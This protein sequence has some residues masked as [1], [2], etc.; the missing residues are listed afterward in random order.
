MAKYTM[1]LRDIVESQNV[2]LFDFDYEYYADNYALQ[3]RFE[4]M[5][6]QHYYFHEIG[7]ETVERFK[8]NL[9]AKL[10]LNAPLYR[11]YWDSYLKSKNIDFTVN[12]EYLETVTR[13][14]T[15]ENESSSN[16][17]NSTISRNEGENSYNGTTKTSSLADGVS[18][19]R[20][21][22]DYVTGITHD[23]NKTKTEDV[24]HAEESGDSNT[25]GSGKQSETLTTSAKGNIGTTS[26][27]QLIKEW[28]DIMLNLDRQLIEECADLFMQVY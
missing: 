19:A 16:S 26:S 1:E 5:F 25:R 13:E 24:H 18:K 27:A 3:K 17:L 15:T 12:K 8:W 21:D 7:F 9:K 11:Q 14:L 6:V 22:D 28:R 23:A 2:N 4:N 20:I 10:N